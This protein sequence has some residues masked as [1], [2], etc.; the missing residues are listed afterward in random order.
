MSA[1]RLRVAILSFFTVFAVVFGAGELRRRANAEQATRAAGQG[2]ASTLDVSV[3]EGTS[4]SVAVSPDGRTLAID[5]QGSIWTLS[6]TGGTAKRITDLLIDAHQPV[7]SPDGKSIAFFAYTEGG[8]DIWSMAPDGSNQHKLTWGPFDDREPIWSHDGTRVAFSSDRGNSLGSDY[9]IWVVD[10][11]TGEIKQLTRNPAE[12]Y[13]PSWSPDDREIAFASSRGGVWAVTV[14]NGTERQVATSQGRV[15]APSWGPA[16]QIVYYSFYSAQGG[17]STLEANGKSL[18]GDENAAPFRVSWASASEFFYVADGKIRKRA[19]NGDDATTIAFTAVVPVT[20]TQY[21]RRKRDF[22]STA[23]RQA[24]GIIRP[25]ISPDG[26][27]I[28]FAA[29]NDIYVMAIGGRPANI[30]NDR[31]LDIDPAWSPDGSQLVYSSDKGG[32]QLQLWIRD[33]RTGQSRQ[34]THLTTQ[35][36]GAAWSP[37]GKRIAFLN[38]NNNYGVAEIAVLDVTTLA[39]AK[40]HDTLPQPGAPAWS[41]DGKRLA[42]AALAPY[43]KR[44]REGTNQVLTMSATASGNDK[45]YEP[46]STLSIDSRADCGPVWSPDGSKMAAIYEGVLAV[47]PVSVSGEPLGPPRRFSTESANAPSWQSDSRHLLYQS[48]DKLKIVDIVT[49]ENREIPLDLKYTPDVPKGRVIVHAGRLVDMKSPTTRTDVDIVIEGNRIRSVEPHSAN[50]HSGGQIV[51]ASNLTVMPGLIE[52]HTHLQPEYG[53]AQSRA[54]LAFGI[55]TVQSL[56]GIPYEAVE[57]RESAE[58]NLRTGPRIFSTGYVLEYQRVFYRMGIAISSPAHLEMEL[59]RAKLLQYDLLKSYVRLPDTLQKRTVDFA[60]SIGIRVATHEIYPASLTGVDDTEHTASTSRRGYSMKQG[61]LNRAYDDFV[62]L[63][64]KSGRTFDA[65]LGEDD[66]GTS[67]L[68]GDESTLKDDPR[69]NLYPAFLQRE[70]AQLNAIGAGRRGQAET[71]LPTSLRGNGKMVMDAMHAGALIVGGTDRPLAIKLHGDIVSDVLIGMTPYEALKT[72]T[73]NPA[74]ALGLDA[75]TI[76]PGKLADLVIVD[77][78]PLENVE[79]A[80]K[81]KRVIANG[82]V[83]ELDDLLKGVEPTRSPAQ[84]VAR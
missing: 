58:A 12:D 63:I 42:L 9:N 56:G 65:T 76:E 29:L 53:E 22:D 34:V 47:W 44:F 71:A 1:K 69:F 73:V 10:I 75:G 74:Q 38:I 25:V 37:D 49:G 66:F 80:H 83:Y 64:G 59:Q 45:W 31:A 54:Y 23:P 52:W 21:A 35:P 6:A 60:H 27:K 16:G 55:T 62:Q 50:A 7:W 46:V 17:R 68:F 39:V 61:P 48:L 30:T 8:Y 15:D 78:N 24:L 43:S 32:N 40:L 33:M 72:V 28:A 36:Q 4:M 70:V 3:N 57:E 2:G 79:K 18:T 19:V 51:D 41:A 67:K 82:H 14:E 84:A 81:V 26:T 13:M 77:G 11:R 5:L 20:R